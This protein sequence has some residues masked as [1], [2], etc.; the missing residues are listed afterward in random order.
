[1]SN[2]AIWT[3]LTVYLA[4]ALAY[5]SFILLTEPLAFSQ[6]RSVLIG[7]IIGTAL[8]MFILPSL[9]PRTEFRHAGTMQ[10]RQTLPL[11]DHEYKSWSSTFG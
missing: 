1:M 3:T 9:A 11:G 7:K 5:A 2:K 6:Y 4:V 10:Y 8:T